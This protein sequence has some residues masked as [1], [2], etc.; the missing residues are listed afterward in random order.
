MIILQQLL[1]YATIK[2]CK[3]VIGLHVLHYFTVKYAM[4]FFIFAMTKQ[5]ERSDILYWPTINQQWLHLVK[6]F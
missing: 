6:M 1:S 5:I 4:S 3:Y 2:V